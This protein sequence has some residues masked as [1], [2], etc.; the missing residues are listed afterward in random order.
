MLPRTAV[1]LTCL[2]AVSGCGSKRSPAGSPTIPTVAAPKPVDPEKA[3]YEEVRD[4]TYQV[5]AALDSLDS[6]ND[7]AQKLSKVA[8]GTAARGFK[9]LLKKLSTAGRDLSDY[10][11]DPPS[12]ED[13]KQDLSNQDEFRLNAIDSANDA[14]G[15]LADAQDIVD[16]LLAGAPPDVK[17]QVQKLQ[18]TLDETVDATESSVTSFGGKLDEDDVAPSISS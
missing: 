16:M 3:L 8:G 11:E 17:P 4:G 2:L 5:Q 1:A 7:Q 6:A 12:F 14:L 9:D 15:E 13:F 10:S 18:D